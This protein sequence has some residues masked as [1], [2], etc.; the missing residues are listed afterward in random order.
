MLLLVTDMVKFRSTKAALIVLTLTLTWLVTACSPQASTSSGEDTVPHLDDLVSAASSGSTEDLL[1]L[2]QFSSLPC[3]KEEGMG[4]PPKCFAD[5]AE[6]TL[7]EVLPILGPEGHHIRRSE[8]SSWPG[9]GDAQL[10]AAYRN[11]DSTYSD[12]F[13]PAGDFGVAFLMPDKVN[14]VVF[15]VTDDGIV[16]IDYN[17]LSSFEDML[18]DSE[19]VVGPTPPSE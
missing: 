6:G 19:V 12:E 8:I 4:G 16:R 11:S 13:F 3:T 5:E 15:Q 14:V 1:A 7:V 10:Y 17:V 2:V 18:R 9:I